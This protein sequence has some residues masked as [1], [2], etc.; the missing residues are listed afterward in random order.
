MSVD[1]QVGKL[2]RNFTI[3]A[4]RD[5]QPTTDDSHH[6]CDVC[7]LERALNTHF[8]A[9]RAVVNVYRL[10]PIISWLLTHSWA[11]IADDS[12]MS[13]ASTTAAIISASLSALPSP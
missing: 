10:R 1:R 3:Y 6:R 9:R 7:P 12:E 4:A 8:P 13:P 2:M 11:R 5:R